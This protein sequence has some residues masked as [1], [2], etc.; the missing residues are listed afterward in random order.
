MRVGYVCQNLAL[1]TRSR[2]LRL[3]NL[4]HERAVA[5]ARE[6]VAAV[7][8]IARWNAEN[9]VGMFRMTS[10]LVPFGSH[11]GSGA[12]REALADDFARAG[13]TVRAAGQRVSTH[14]GQ[15]VVLGSS[16][17]AVLDAGLR[18]LE[19]QADALD[20][21]GVD[22]EMVVHVGGACDDREAALGRFVDRA[23]ALPERVARRL[24]I[25]NDETTYPVGD[26]LRLS[27]ETGLP[28]VFDV[29]HDAL[30][31]TPG[32]SLREGLER[33]LATWARRGRAP[34]VHYSDAD[35][36]GPRGKHARLVDVTRFQ[37]F[38]DGAR[39]LDF[40]VMVEAKEKERAVLPL[41]PLAA[42]HARLTLSGPTRGGAGTRPRG[43]AS[44]GPRERAPRAPRP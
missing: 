6:N 22:A 37:A 38:L 17:E 42:A 43:A 20:L 21:M 12:W 33:S 44:S 34:K 25:E 8:R 24:V 29:L 27:R 13:E 15:F 30:H 35:P 4:T 9:G 11:P 26:A 10:G 41:L 36:A 3:A 1:G 7:E 23:R 2:T 5:L 14:P 16:R 18:E 19:Y 32:L 31:P 28:V 40:D 39:G